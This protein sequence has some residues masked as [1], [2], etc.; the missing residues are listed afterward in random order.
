LDGKYPSQVFLHVLFCNVTHWDPLSVAVDDSDTKDAFRQENAFGVMA[1][2]TVAV[3]D[4]WNAGD[5]SLD[6]KMELSLLD[7]AVAFRVVYP[8]C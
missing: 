3:C 4:R 8:Y 6:N 7:S 2:G 5:P 1:Q